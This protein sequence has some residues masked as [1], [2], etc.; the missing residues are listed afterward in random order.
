MARFLS[1][2]GAESPLGRS[3][4]TQRFM[5]VSTPPPSEPGVRLSPHRA[6]QS[7]AFRR[8]DY[9]QFCQPTFPFAAFVLRLAHEFTQALCCYLSTLSGSV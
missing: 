3:V 6:L 9:S 2:V 5:D 1:G 8:W 7:L 4:Y